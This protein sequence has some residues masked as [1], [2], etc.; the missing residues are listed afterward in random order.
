MSLFNC[1][2]Q[3]RTSQTSAS[4]MEAAKAAREAQEEASRLQVH[5]PTHP[6]N[7]H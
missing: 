4:E 6:P 2:F 1:G 5:P 7:H 3:K